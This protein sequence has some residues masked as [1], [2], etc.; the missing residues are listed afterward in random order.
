MTSLGQKDLAD[1]AS[2]YIIE[3]I[4]SMK[5]DEIQE[6]MEL[7][8]DTWNYVQGLKLLREIGVNLPEWD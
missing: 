6:F 1:L 8:D 7:L 2:L 4:P 5:S 3:R